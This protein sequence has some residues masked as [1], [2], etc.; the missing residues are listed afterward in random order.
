MVQGKTQRQG[1]VQ[2]KQQGRKEQET[3][4][5]MCRE[6]WTLRC[7]DCW[8]SVLFCVSCG[9]NHHNTLTEKVSTS[10]TQ[11]PRRK[12]LET[13]C[14]S[15][16]DTHTSCSTRALS[17]HADTRSWSPPRSSLLGTP[18]THPLLLCFPPPSAFLCLCLCLCL[19]LFLLVFRLLLVLSFCSSSFS[20]FSVPLLHH[21][22]CPPNELFLV[23]SARNAKVI[24]RTTIGQ[25]NTTI[26]W[27]MR[28]LS[29]KYAPTVPSDCLDVYSRRVASDPVRDRALQY[30]TAKATYHTPSP[31][32]EVR[33]V[34][35][36]LHQHLGC[37]HWPTN[38]TL[39]S[40]T[41]VRFAAE[42]KQRLEARHSSTPM[43][44][45]TLHGNVS[46]HPTSLIRAHH[47]RNLSSS[48][49]ELLRTCFSSH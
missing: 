4:E 37:V 11:L 46:A 24:K 28:T 33:F 3:M 16:P 25:H 32:Q 49:F 35:I 47:S 23:Q 39:G 21:T 14:K 1:K 9:P 44:L 22:A 48:S 34:S 15:V 40:M 26:N 20:I 5:N 42:G 29:K 19:I 43:E 13:P 18:A 6:P 27:V 12:F 36:G 17:C 7:Q 38:H 10:K 31:V 2:R 41:K 30:S 8:R 45:P